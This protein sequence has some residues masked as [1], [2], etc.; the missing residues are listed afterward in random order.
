LYITVICDTVYFLDPQSLYLFKIVITELTLIIV[1]KS[2]LKFCK[3][4]NL[5]LYCFLRFL[6]LPL[7]NKSNEKINF[8]YISQAHCCIFYQ[9][10]DNSVCT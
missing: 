3:N 8:L 2:I 9:Q 1:I 7:N 10:S 6:K 5:N 4:T